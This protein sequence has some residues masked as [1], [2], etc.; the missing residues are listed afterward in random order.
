M[1]R[2]IPI[3][4]KMKLFG[5]MRMKRGAHITVDYPFGSF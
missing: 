4:L 3:P 1:G 5:K 2:L